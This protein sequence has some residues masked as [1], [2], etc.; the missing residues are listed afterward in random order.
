MWTLILAAIAWA[1]T[2]GYLGVQ[3]A[4]T[5]A[6]GPLNG[7][8]DV[9]FRLYADPGAAPTISVT[10]AVTFTSGA[11][12]HRL[13]ID[14]EALGAAADPQITVQ[15]P[16]GPEG[17]KMPVDWVPRAAYALDA[18]RFGG[19]NPSEYYAVGDALPWTEISGRPQEL[20]SA[21]A[22][23][24][25]VRDVAYDAPE[26]LFAQLDARYQRVGS[27]GGLD[28]PTGDLTVGTGLLQLGQNTDGACSTPE[29]L[30][31]MRWNGAAFQ[32]CGPDG[33]MNLV[34]SSGGVS[35]LESGMIAF[36]PGACPDGWAEYTPLRGRVVVGVAAG[37]VVE[38]TVGTA[39]AAGG[40]RTITSVPSHTHS[41]DPT[42]FD[43][44]SG[45]SHA[46]SVDPP[47]TGTTTDGAH[48]HSFNDFHYIDSGADPNYATGSG[49]DVGQRTT[50]GNST[51]SAG[52]HNHNVDIT[53]F[54]SASA[55]AHTHAVDV[56]ATTTSAT[57]V[58]AV[59][60]TMPYV[61][62]VGCELQ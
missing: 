38:A 37:G 51:A 23:A 15:L 27:G 29:H 31:R 40:T 17:E 20:D 35:S 11:F 4:V 12:A 47:S 8:S 62:L 52:S 44:A 59:D 54:S 33:W 28:L 21:I 2:P 60:V 61:Q 55:G 50:S 42:S 49:D 43:A 3:G 24:A 41:V 48:S 5:S 53:A 1:E 26:E 6:S 22:V 9:T 30:G 45:G 36:F 13:L 56:P 18:Q 34:S 58:A 14:L 10:Q 16:G 46:H 39:L 19:L 7:T 25:Y 57:G 32:G